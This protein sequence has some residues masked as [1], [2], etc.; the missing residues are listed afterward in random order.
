MRIYLGGLAVYLL[1]AMSVA[2]DP[3]ELPPEGFV[4]RA[5]VDSEGCAFT[6]ARLNDT[7]VWVARLDAGRV[8]VC[9]EV[10]T[11]AGNSARVL[12]TS[13]V[14]VAMAQASAPTVIKRAPPVARS[15]PSG[16][17]PAWTDGRLNPDRG[18]R[19]AAG[20]AAMS[21]VWS[22]KVPMVRRAD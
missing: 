8:P 18:P 3:A 4:G 17:K 22:N 13:P 20:N 2:A 5:F 19:T 12:V 7:T 6:R 16:F 1:A 10:P 21:R 11:F 15:A 14:S 9:D